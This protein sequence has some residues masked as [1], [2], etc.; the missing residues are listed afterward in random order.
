MIN[1][2]ILRSR[3]ESRAGRKIPEPMLMVARGVGQVFFQECALSGVL[4]LVGIALSSPLM[5]LG[6]LIGAVVGTAVGLLLKYD[7]GEVNA[8]I[9][10]FNATLVGV[11]SFFFF[12]PGVLT[13]ILLLAGALAA[14]VVTWLVRRYVPFPTYTAP[15]I[16]VTWVL[17]L[18]GGA[19]G[20]PR[21]V[22]GPALEGVDPAL[23]VAHGVS[24]VMFQAS[25]FTALFFIAGIAV[26][27][28]RHAAW[29]VAGA[30][31]GMLL[32]GFHATASFRLPD[33]ES[34]VERGLL[35][36]VGLGLYGYN[37]PLAAVALFLWRRSAIPAVL[38]MLLTVPLTDLIPL[39]GLPALT[40][41]FVLASWLVQVFGWLDRHLFH[42]ASDAAPA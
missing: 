17:F 5:A 31:V 14:T 29:V 9:Y 26:S 40:A 19:L 15:F 11:A 13:L 6:G 34:L 16:V 37:A 3:L 20:V 36:N 38:G 18:V 8:G 24:Q 4:F 39:A 27:D 33:P 22:P 1:L 32:G 10:G 21:V 25:W 23:A 41:P 28:L 2:E 30:T 12:Q 35:E 7:A 42:D